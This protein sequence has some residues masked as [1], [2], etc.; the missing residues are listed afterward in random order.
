MSDEGARAK[1]E[2]NTIPI[3]GGRHGITKRESYVRDVN[4]RISNARDAD[5][6][7]R[8]IDSVKDTLKKST[9]EQRNQP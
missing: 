5:G 1:G 3:S 4:G 9:L 6:T 7:Q 8:E 2:N